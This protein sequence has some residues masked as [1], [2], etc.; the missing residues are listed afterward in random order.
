M[1]P[2]RLYT[3]CPSFAGMISLAGGKVVVG[4]FRFDQRQSIPAGCPLYPAKILPFPGSTSQNHQVLYNACV[5][6]SYF[7]FQIARRKMLRGYPT[8]LKFTRTHRRLFRRFVSF[9]FCRREDS[10][11]F[12]MCICFCAT[13]GIKIFIV[14]VANN[15]LPRLRLFRC[16]K[17]KKAP[18]SPAAFYF[19][20]WLLLRATRGTAVF[21][22]DR[23]GKGSLRLLCMPVLRRQYLCSC[24]VKYRPLMKLE[25]AALARENY[26]TLRC[27]TPQL[28]RRHTCLNLL[29]V[30]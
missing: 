30:R 5:G 18:G 23:A 15:Y 24:R 22:Q 10:S 7:S 4:V 25:A 21:L 26:T 20:C 29:S 8:S 12:A 13:R 1:T 2:I 6:D 3:R 11:L 28:F 9:Q 14:L 27:S 19:N 16:R 17:P